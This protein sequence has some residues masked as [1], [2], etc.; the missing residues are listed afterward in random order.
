M[1]K[2]LLTQDNPKIF[3]WSPEDWKTLL[4]PS[5]QA[6]SGQI[7]YPPGRHHG[8]SPGS[9]CSSSDRGA[10]AV[11]EEMRSFTSQRGA[12]RFL[13]GGKKCCQYSFR[14]NPSRG[15]FFSVPNFAS[16]WSV[17]LLCAL[18]HNRA[19]FGSFVF[20]VSKTRCE[21]PLWA[22]NLS[23]KRAVEKYRSSPPEHESV[24]SRFCCFGGRHATAP[25]YYGVG[26][27]I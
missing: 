22:L 2:T 8:S 7:S 9:K 27:A 16:V 19:T 5:L 12:P 1:N 3:Q 6:Y 18:D 23:P 10:F 15:R 20:V 17:L 26:P 21:S 25:T 13:T 11:S 24:A 14:N 4:C